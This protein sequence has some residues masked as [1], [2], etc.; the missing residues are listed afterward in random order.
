MSN[1]LL[2]MITFT[3][4]A[5]LRNFQKAAQELDVSAGVITRRVQALEDSLGIRLISR[6]SRP[7]ALTPAGDRY[8]VFCMATLEAIE[9]EELALRSFQDQ[10]SGTL[11]VVVPM[12]LGAI[13]LAKAQFRFNQLYPEI[14]VRLVLAD[15]WN[16]TFDPKDYKADVL[17]RSTRPK[18]SSLK[19]RRLATFTWVVC[20]TP[21]Y[22]EQHTIPSHPSDLIKHSCLL[23]NRPFSD[24]IVRFRYQGTPVAVRISGSIAP[25]NAVAMWLLVRQS[26]GIGILPLFCVRK[27]LESGDLVQILNE[28]KISNQ[29]IWSYHGYGAKPP[30]RV[31]LYLNFISDW[32]MAS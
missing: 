6:A 18:N 25:S 26:L 21:E 23:P 16:E 1:R 13:S 22:L 14:S 31:R 10:A 29:P 11:T 7:L 20:A 24:G 17:I 8:L 2:E 5:R 19:S 27:E 12:S 32:L 9:E 4:V 30:M 15:H 28:Y 3:K